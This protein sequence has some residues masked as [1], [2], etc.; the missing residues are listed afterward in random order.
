MRPLLKKIIIV[1]SIFLCA[2]IGFFMYQINSGEAAFA[3]NLNLGNK[4]LL[5][6]DYDNAIRAFSEAIAIDGMNTEAY[7]GRGDAYKAKGDYANAWADYEKAQELSGD[8]ELLMKKIGTTEINVLSG[9]GEGIDGAVIKLTG[10]TRSYE[11]ITE[12]GFATE[13]LF[14]EKYEMKISREGYETCEKELSAENGANVTEPI[15]IQLDAKRVAAAEIFTEYISQK[16]CMYGKKARFTL[17][18]RKSTDNNGNW[19]YERS[20]EG[21]SEGTVLGYSIED[22]DNDDRDELLLIVLVEDEKLQLEMYEAGDETAELADTRYL[23]TDTVYGAVPLPTGRASEHT[24]CGFLSAFVNDSDHRIYVQSSEYGLIADGN[25]TFVVST[26]YENNTF[27]DYKSSHAIG[28][29]IEDSIPDRVQELKDMGVPNI[30]FDVYD[31]IFYSLAPVYDCFGDGV[32]EILHAEQYTTEVEKEEYVTVKIVTETLY[33]TQDGQRGESSEYSENNQ[34]PVT[35][36]VSV[37]DFVNGFWMSSDELAS[38]FGSPD[39]QYTERFQ[40]YYVY[41]NVECLGNDGKISCQIGEDD[42][43]HSVSWFSYEPNMD[44]FNA[45][46]SD[47]NESMSMYPDPYADEPFNNY[48]GQDGSNRI[49]IRYS[50]EEA[51]TSIQWSYV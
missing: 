17:V 8:N 30:D 23:D 35:R 21:L 47:T 48:M 16:D 14:P 29:S 51:Q 31:R 13:L 20:W 5:S 42:M 32:H 37:E 43:V 40:N 49:N 46:V 41:E 39:S 22:F 10:A 24:I 12:N 45:F 50:E 19:L 26:V 4:Y 38:R 11:L 44:L 1:L 2:E 18:R 3:R 9:S 28:S 33:T 34:T 6:Q 36:T 25:Q 7:I 27:S 15:K